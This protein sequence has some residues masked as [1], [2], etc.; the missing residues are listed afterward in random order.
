MGAGYKDMYV[1]QEQ[2][3]RDEFFSLTLMGTVQRAGVYKPNTPEKKR[4]EFQ[5]T[6]REWLEQIVQS[7]KEKISEDAHIKNIL[8]LSNHLSTVHADILQ[9]GRF[10]IGQAQKALNLYLKYLWCLRR[11]A[12]SPH[13][14]FDYQIIS[15]LP[16]YDGPKWTII[17]KVED[18][19]KLVAAAKAN[20]GELSLSR[21]EL[22]TYNNAKQGSASDTASLR[23]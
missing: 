2:F 15:K 3:L 10:R 16:S 20:A 14:P 7:Y 12:E 5:S 11:I 21:W 23:R 17:D 13:C 8:E 4:K 19:R 22:E 1:Y 9:C 18:Y 6:L